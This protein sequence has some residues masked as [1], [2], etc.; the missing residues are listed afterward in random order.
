MALKNLSRVP[1]IWHSPLSRWNALVQPWTRQ[2]FDDFMELDMNFR[3][4]EN[5]N[6]DMV[7]RMDMP[8]IRKQDL[9]VHVENDVLS[10]YGNRRVVFDDERNEKP[11]QEQD[12]GSGKKAEEFIQV[13]RSL[14]IPK[15]F[16]ASKVSAKLEDGVLSVLIAKAADQNA[17]KAHKIVIE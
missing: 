14:M 1:S 8:G 10:V 12:D 11:E 6:G 2:M 7:V 15:N 16:D 13:K 3:S 9:Q 17:S 5:K 4:Y